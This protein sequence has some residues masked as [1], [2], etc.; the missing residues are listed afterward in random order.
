M[1]S[2]EYFQWIM[3]QEYPGLSRTLSDEDHIMLED[4]FCL[5]EINVYHL[6]IDVIEMKLT[7]KRDEENVFFLHFELKDAEYAKKLSEAKAKAEEVI[8]FVE[9]KLT[10]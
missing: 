10:K 7:R 8:R 9:E 1:N 2:R 6:E 3:E 4:D 5:G